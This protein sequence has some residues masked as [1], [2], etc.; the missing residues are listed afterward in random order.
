MWTDGYI[1]NLGVGD[2]VRKATRQYAE[3]SVAAKYRMLSAKG[4]QAHKMT[5]K[6]VIQ[7]K[8][9]VLEDQYGGHRQPE[10]QED[11]RRLGL[12]SGRGGVEAKDAFACDL[13]LTIV[14]FLLQC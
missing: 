1:D 8:R 10:R 5:P 3:W 11:C 4:V 12:A 6:G 9:V 14:E 2:N 13:L 7:R